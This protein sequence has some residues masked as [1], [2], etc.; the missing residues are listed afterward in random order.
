MKIKDMS[1]FS[2]IFLLV[3]SIFVVLLIAAAIVLWSFLDAFESTRPDNVA[4]SFFNKSFKIGNIGYLVEQYAPGS[5]KFETKDSINTEFKKNYD[6]SKLNFF[7]TASNPDGSEEYTVTN[8]NSE[9]AKFTLSVDK[10]EGFGLKGYKVADVDFT[11]ENNRSAE[12]LVKKGF[13]LKINDIEVDSS[14]IT[15]T[16]IKD[17]S[18]SHMPKGVEGIL[19]DKYTVSSLFFEPLAVVISPEGNEELT[20]YDE[21]TKCYTVAKVYSAE[22]QNEH[23]S[24]AIKAITEYAKYLSNNSEFT[25]IAPFLDS[26]A[27]LYKDIETVSTSW[28]W[29]HKSYRI[30]DEKACDFI[31][32][33]NEVFSCRVSLKDTLISY[34]NKEHIE[35]VD[36]TVYF[37]HVGG[38]YL[39]YDMVNN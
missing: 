21:D 9:L 18:Y 12:I 17:A 37:R 14:Y 16:D 39:I 1:L 31:K 27:K 11:F 2:K 28:L 35:I 19:Y 5:L 29:K 38:K 4:Q 36:V 34:E 26:S 10:S 6:L 20:E 15:E 32:Y 13:K 7:A 3:V 30:S 8:N 23:S 24:Y 22:L 33:T 25:N